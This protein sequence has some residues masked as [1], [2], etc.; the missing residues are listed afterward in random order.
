MHIAREHFG[1]E[2]ERPLVDPQTA[3]GY[4]L[5]Q[6]TWDASIWSQHSNLARQLTFE[7]GTVR[8]DGIVVLVEFVDSAGPDAIAITVE[9]DLEGH[10]QPCAYVRRGGEVTEEVF[11]PAWMN[12]FRTD[13][14]HARL[15][16]LVGNL[17]R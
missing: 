16:E 9:T 1:V 15:A 3:V 5:E 7:N 6:A 8:D 12:D 17:G 4:L 11:S 13:E 10:I 14:N 2:F